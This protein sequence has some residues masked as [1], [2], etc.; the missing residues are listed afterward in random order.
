MSGLNKYFAPITIAGEHLDNFK[1]YKMDS[2]A[3]GSNMRKDVGLGT[4]NCCDYFQIKSGTIW[5]FEETD[6][7]HQIMDLTH[8]A[9]YELLKKDV[10]SKLVE[11]LILNENRLKVYGSMLVLCR[12]AAKYACVSEKLGNKPVEF[13]LIDSHVAS[14]ESVRF[15]DNIRARILN[16]LKSLLT[17]QVVAN[18]E[19]LNREM[20][21]DKLSNQAVT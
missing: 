21:R 19:I 4:C 17:S 6:L 2:T 12:F 10:R 20:M 1:A 11:R 13:L 3:A 5:L 8:S 18:V 15:Y 9:D 14:D 16:D 7:T